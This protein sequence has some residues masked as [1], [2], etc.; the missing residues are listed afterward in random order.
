MRTGE[1]KVVGENHRML[2][3]LVRV[4]VRRQE[5]TMQRA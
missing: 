4:S 2:A 3:V 1:R 5:T